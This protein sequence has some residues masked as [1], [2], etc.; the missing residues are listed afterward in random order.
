MSDQKW[1]RFA[2]V[3]VSVAGS[4]VAFYVLFKFAVGIFLPFLTAFLVAT[5]ARAGAGRL[6]KKLRMGERPL[7]ILLVLLVLVLLA[8]GTYALCGKALLE[9]QE[10]LRHLLADSDDPNGTLARVWDFFRRLGERFSFIAEGDLF[11]SFIGDPAD[12]LADQLRKFLSGLSERLPAGVSALFSALP[13]ILLFLAVTVIACFY[14]TLDYPRVVG[15]LC[16]L[17]PPRL[18]ERIPAWRGRVGVV[19]TQYL[20]AY[21]L[22]FLLTMGEVWLGLLILRVRYSFLLSIL[23]GLL[24]ALPVLGVGT[25]LVPWGVL[26]LIG[27]NPHLGVGLL[28]LFAVVTVVRQVIEPHLVGKSLGLHPLLMLIGF[29]AG[30]KLFGVTGVFVG[31]IAMLALKALRQG[32]GA[33]AKE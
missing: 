24:D 4:L 12:F 17:V 26:A 28:L 2:A 19:L 22:L 13:R 23:I 3:T 33:R 25:V 31:P 9:L 15:T 11:A 6:H 8:W 32:G 1:M 7:S 5:V 27:G 29:Y 16:R 14:V 18:R 20:R 10:L 21:L 30:I